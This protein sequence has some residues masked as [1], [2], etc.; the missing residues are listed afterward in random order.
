MLAAASRGIGFIRQI[1]E[2]S[3]TLYKGRQ[4]RSSLKSPRTSEDNA[5]GK[6]YD[7]DWSEDWLSVKPSSSSQEDLLGDGPEV[8]GGQHFH[9]IATTILSKNLIKSVGLT[10]ILQNLIFN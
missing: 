4:E 9:L 6:P 3:W 8:L 10:E 1:S 7:S 2:P 5:L